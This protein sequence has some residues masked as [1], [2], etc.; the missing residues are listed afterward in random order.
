MFY[1]ATRFIREGYKHA[2]RSKG[3]RFS[4]KGAEKAAETGFQRFARLA[5]ESKQALVNTLGVYFVLSYSVHNYRVE[6]AWNERELEFKAL[7]EEVLRMKNTLTSEEWIQSTEKT[8]KSNRKSILGDEISKV[9][10]V[11]GDRERVLD[12]QIKSAPG[13]SE[14]LAELASL[15][16]G[17]GKTEKTKTSVKIV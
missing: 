1:H 10:Q 14:G 3:R 16:D 6:K 8:V 9:L 5:S 11:R 13:G 7:E 17:G 15:V 12:K 2:F 4:S